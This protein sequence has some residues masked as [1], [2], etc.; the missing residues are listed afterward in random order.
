MSTAAPWRRS[1]AVAVAALVSVTAIWGSTFLF[2]KDAIA[3]MPPADF[4]GLRFLIATV[5]MIALRPA[6]V[7]AL[8]VRGVRH[9][10]LLGLALG[11]GYVAQTFGLQ[12]TSV[13]VSGFITGMFVVFTP[14]LSGLVLRRPVPGLAW[15]GV[16]LATVGLAL[17][18]LHGLSV[19]TGEALSLLGALAFAAHIVGLGEWSSQ[20][21]PYGLA[22]VQLGVVAALSLLMAAPGGVAIP[23][24]V[25]VWAAVI[26]TAVFATA[27][28]FVVQTWVQARLAPTRTAVILTM[29]PVFAALTAF[30]AGDRPGGRTLVGG[31]LV[32]AAMYLVELGPR[33]SAEGTIPHLE[34]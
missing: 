31:A 29:E 11:S 19:G 24:D 1:D 4:L 6:R 18:A 20:D 5:L 15:A 28:A 22:V 33:R 25:G 23:P 16:A 10:A 34:S 14:L 27:L 21:D 26:G 12:T 9:G 30:L 13:T 32:A 3:R 2:V 17:L 8:G 7:R